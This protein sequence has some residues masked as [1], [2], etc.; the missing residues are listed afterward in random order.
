MNDTVAI[1]TNLPM[2]KIPALQA[3]VRD[4]HPLFERLYPIGIV[5]EDRLLVYDVDPGRRSYRLVR[6]SVIPG[7]VF[8]RTRTTVPL[9]DYGNRP[10]CVVTRDAFDSVDDCIAVLHEF[11]HCAQWEDCES[12]LAT[13]LT[14]AYKRVGQVHVWEA[15]YRFGYDN[16]R[17]VYAYR[18][19]L[20]ALEAGDL[21]TGLSWHADAVAALTSL[22]REFM[23]WHEWKEGFARWLEN[24]A[25]RRLGV[26]RNENGRFGAF[27]PEAFHAGGAE[28]IQLLVRTEP[29]LANQ[30]AGLYHRIHEAC[31]TLVSTEL[32]SP[33]AVPGPSPA[34]GAQV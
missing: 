34:V 14:M 30:F 2:R 6:N 23:L 1:M 4:L 7:P 18:H 3:A 5:E 15:R 17:L 26:R 29:Q 20:A 8:E 12:E 11:V 33:A 32:D 19:M 28:L 10:V 31:G 27:G 13:A 22:D 25:R 21:A 9:P 24:R 16:D